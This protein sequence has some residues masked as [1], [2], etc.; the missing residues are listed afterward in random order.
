MRERDKNQHMT[1]TT[2]IYCIPTMQRVVKDDMTLMM[3][4][5][6]EEPAGSRR[7]E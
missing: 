1:A 6:F 2:T 3:D 7:S 5:S 4:S